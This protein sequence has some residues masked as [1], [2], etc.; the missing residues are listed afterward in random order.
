MNP[1]RS[2]LGYSRCFMIT[3]VKSSYIFCVP[4]YRGHCSLVVLEVVIVYSIRNAKL[5]F[6]ASFKAF[7]DIF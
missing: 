2:L 7:R 5:S 6:V 1:M 4:I 3:N